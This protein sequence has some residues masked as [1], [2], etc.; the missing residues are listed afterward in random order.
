M[1]QLTNLTPYSADLF[2]FYGHDER[3]WHLAVLRASFSAA[4]GRDTVLADEQPP[5]RTADEHNGAPEHSSVRHEADIALEKPFP[6]VLAAG[7][8]WGPGG[9]PAESVRVSVRVG[10]VHK[11]LQVTGDRFWMRNVVWTPSAPQPFERMPIVY[12]RAFGGT[13]PVEGGACERRNPVGVGME[14]ARSAD[15]RVLTEIPNVEYP[16]ALVQGPGDRAAPA[17]FGPVGRSWTPRVEHAG[18]YGEAWLR[19]RFPLLPPDFDPRYYQAAP[20]DQQSRALVA[21]S[22]VEVLGMT[23]EGVWRFALP[24]VEV[25]VTLWYDRPF[26]VPPL[27]LDTVLLEPDAYRVTLTLRARFA[28][29]RGRAPLREV[30][31]GGLTPGRLRAR[32]TG[33]TYLD[34]TAHRDLSAGGEE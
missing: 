25:P 6:E 20:P 12:E 34:W 21:G 28:P 2:C 31:L 24:A 22:P 30:V 9:R 16:S 23:P 32:V 1:P 8:A 17:G 26:P 13:V 14:G 10:D 7:H 29:A 18:T 15:P 4:P 33:K 11:E 5:V 19:D 27:R 3:R